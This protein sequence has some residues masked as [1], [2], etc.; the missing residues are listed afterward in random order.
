M[1]LPKN[2]EKIKVGKLLGFVPGKIY[3]TLNDFKT[4]IGKNRKNYHKDPQHLH[5]PSGKI[6]QL[7]DISFK[8]LKEGRLC[9]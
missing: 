8:K 6:L 7:G 2:K 4:I 3:E 9:H 1:I 5:F